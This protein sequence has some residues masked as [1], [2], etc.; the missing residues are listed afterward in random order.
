MAEHKGYAIAT[1]M[2]VLSGVLTGSKFGADVAGPYQT[3]RASGCGHLMIALHTDAIEPL[4]EFDARMEQPVGQ[5]KAAPLA[6][7]FKEIVYPG[8]LESRNDAKNRQEGLLLP[9]DTLMDLRKLAAETGLADRL[10]FRVE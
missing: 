7:G 1:M 5:Y 3:E 9:D 10:P 4:A 6:K 8:E 2:D